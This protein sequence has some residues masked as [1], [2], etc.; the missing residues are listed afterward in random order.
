MLGY[1]SFFSGLNSKPALKVNQAFLEL[2]MSR[3]NFDLKHPQ[4]TIV[5]DSN[6]WFR[7]LVYGCKIQI[8]EIC[9]Q[10]NYFQDNVAN[11]FC[12]GWGVQGT[13]LLNQ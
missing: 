3:S 10:Q 11:T 9:E 2:S 1:L 7:K 12:I 8:A 13:S 4:N 6:L 5:F